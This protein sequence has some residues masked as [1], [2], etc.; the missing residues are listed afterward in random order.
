M[1]FHV[2]LKPQTSVASIAAA[3]QSQSASTRDVNA[4]AVDEKTRHAWAGRPR[5]R[6]GSQISLTNRSR[7]TRT[8]Y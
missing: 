3:P 7:N 6:F 5:R 1:S 2:W 8:C 4:N